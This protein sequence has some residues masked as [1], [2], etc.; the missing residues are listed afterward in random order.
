MFLIGS[1][2][3]GRHVEQHD[4]FFCVC[5]QPKDAV[6][7]MISFWPEAEGKLHVD[8]WRE[9]RFVDGHEIRVIPKDPGIHETNKLFFINLGGYKPGEFEEFHYKMLAVAPDK[10]HAIQKARSTAFYKHTGFTGAPSHVDD[11]FG[12]DVDDAH[13]IT[14]ILPPGHKDKFSLQI[15]PVSDPG[16]DEIHL[17]YFR[18]EK[19]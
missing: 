19:L 14:D 6:P 3:R 13:E 2:P 8:S 15:T 12:I 11:K 17:G 9:I 18:L 4:V 1:S 10:G 16:T 5:N 7:A